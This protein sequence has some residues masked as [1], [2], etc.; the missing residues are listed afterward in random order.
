M[1][2]HFIIEADG[3]SRGNPGSSGS[4]AIIID[5]E[6]GELVHELSVYIG[7]ATNNVAEYRALLAAIQE[8]LRLDESARVTVRMDSKL[9][10]EQ[11][12]GAWKIK[13]PDMRAL[14]DEI[15]ELTQSLVVD[16]V[17]IPRE[18][19][20]RADALA[21]L[22]MD[23]RSS[24]E[25]GLIAQGDTQKVL[26]SNVVEFN[27]TKPSSVRA[28]GA[29]TQPATT[30]ILV[31]HGRTH[32]T[33]SQRISGSGGLN[34]SLSEAGLADAQKVAI[35]LAE[36]GRRGVFGH[37]NTPTA[38]ISSPIARALETAATIA[39]KLSLS[40]EIEAELSEIGFGD[41]DGLTYEEAKAQSAETFESWRGSWN[42]APPNG[43]S[44]EEFDLRVQRGLDKILM[45]H[46]GST[47]VV[48]S[49]VMPIRGIIRKALGASANAY[50]SIQ[51]GP[52]SISVLRFW[53]DQA[54]EV[55]A[56]NSTKHLA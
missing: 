50:W 5:A 10:I 48:V 23:M 13:H 52:C 31:R 35:E 34:P 54:G 25:P 56:V 49:H 20:S 7:Q 21:N 16:Y 33:E 44:L 30:L 39:Q 46:P 19:N 37:M 55:V 15:S 28:P 4:G 27:T 24:L 26:A 38:V 11:M 45:E 40:V 22:A 43:E 12:R 32:L 8:V 1:T 51:V 36:F 6:T 2:N 41:W 18:L 17:W 47:I 9:V 42:V 29:V 14:A 3:G 53:G